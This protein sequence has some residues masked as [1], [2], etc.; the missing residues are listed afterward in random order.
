MPRAP[1]RWE[2]GWVG[3]GQVPVCRLSGEQ[4]KA[5]KAPSHAAP[6][7]LT[8]P[9]AAHYS[10]P[11]FQNSSLCCSTPSTTPQPSLDFLPECRGGTCGG[12]ACTEVT[13][14]SEFS[15]KALTSPHCLSA[16][17]I[18]FQGVWFRG[19]WHIPDRIKVE[20]PSH[21]PGPPQSLGSGSAVPGHSLQGG[22]MVGR[23]HSQVP[24][25]GH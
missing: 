11:S 23:P 4:G 15:Y 7:A 17:G 1:L 18:S 9:H 24:G 13:P 22:P 10:F 19:T 6:P 16:T 8:A 5:G 2:L 3:P 14:P 21:H 25:V 12:S 20:P